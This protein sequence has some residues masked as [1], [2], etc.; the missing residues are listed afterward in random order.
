M[1]RF[2]LESIRAQVWPNVEIIVVDGGSTDGTIEEL[3][4]QNDIVL[5]KGPDRGVY[6]GINKG[7]QRATG[8]VVGLLNSD[9]VYEFGAFSAVADAFATHKAA[10][11]VCGTS[12]LKDENRNLAIYDREGDKALTSPRS[13]FMGSC[14][15]N[16]RFFRREAMQAIG[17]FNLDYRYI[18]DRDWLARWF[19]SGNTTIPLSETVYTYRQHP[20]SM[21]FDAASSNNDKI[22]AELLLLAQRWRS[23]DQAS[24][25]TRH[26]ATLLEGRCIARLAIAAI[27]DYKLADAIRRIASNAD[28]RVSLAPIKLIS[29]S[30]ADWVLEKLRTSRG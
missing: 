10:D 16:A 3:E 28:N 30:S 22:R 7:I 25:T 6:D 14:T 26:F 5:M 4:P 18:A 24:E 11:A 9:D 29:L 20:G 8:T 19:E 27:R 12:L 23:D 17:P 15:P 2:A 21:T 1:L 13:V